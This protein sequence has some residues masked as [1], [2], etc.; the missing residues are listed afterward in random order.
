MN[1]AS[2][3]RVVFAKGGEEEVLDAEVLRS[4]KD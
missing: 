4:V 2:E 3:H 1:P